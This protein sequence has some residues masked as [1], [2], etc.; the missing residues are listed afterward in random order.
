MAVNLV[1]CWKLHWEGWVG[2]LTPLAHLCT[3]PLQRTL[4]ACWAE[5]APQLPVQW[6][7]Y[8]L[9]KRTYYLPCL[10]SILLGGYLGGIVSLLH[11]NWGGGDSCA[12]LDCRAIT[13]EWVCWGWWWWWWWWWWGGGVSGGSHITFARRWSHREGSSI[14]CLWRNLQLFVHAKWRCGGS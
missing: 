7:A 3:K 12:C 6:Y 14:P 1:I 5:F 2:V 10:P 4:L 11:H 13:G 9:T 8:G